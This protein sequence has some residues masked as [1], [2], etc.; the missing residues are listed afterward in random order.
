MKLDLLL[1]FADWLEHNIQDESFDFRNVVSTFDDVNICGT[2]CCAVGW[3]PKFDSDVAKTGL[4]K[5]SSGSRNLIYSHE[6]TVCS[7]F[8]E[9]AECYFGILFDEAYYLFSPDEQDRII[10][11]GDY[12]V[13]GDDATPSQVADAIRHYVEVVELRAEKDYY[14]FTADS[15]DEAMLAVKGGIDF[16]SE[17]TT[18]QLIH[19]ISH[20]ETVNG[21][22][23]WYNNITDTYHFTEEVQS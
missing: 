15:Y 18:C 8:A 20:L 16:Q 12:P 9:I 22:D 17:P 14:D 23:V 7:H 5:W 6:G 4:V 13:C 19:P 2:I 21:V 10:D 1:S 11:W 3:L